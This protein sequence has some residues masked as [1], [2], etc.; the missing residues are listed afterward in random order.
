MHYNA[1]ISYKHAEHDI[2]IAETVQHSL[3][4]FH[5]PRKLQKK[6]GMK[7]IQRVFR[8]KDE[9]PITSDLS[10]EIAT[11]L[12][13]ADRL[14]VICSPAAKESIWVQREIEFFLR[15]HSKREIFTVL[16]EGEPVEVI[17]EILLTGERVIKD[18]YGREKIVDV[19]VEPLS[20]DFR[21]SLKRAKKEELPRLAS[22]IIGCSYDELMNRRRQYKMR[23]MSIIFAGVMLLAL[24]FGAYMYLSKKEIHKN[25]L[26]S[27][28]NQSRYLANESQRVLDKEQRILALQLALEALPDK[29]S[30]RPVTAEAVR[31][32]TDASLAYV[33]LQ[34]SNIDSV[35]NYRLPNMI[36]DFLLSPEGTTLAARDNGNTL[37]IW[38]TRTHE[39]IIEVSD[40]STNIIGMIYADDSTFLVWS[41][42]KI[43]AYNLTKRES[44]WTYTAS[45]EQFVQK[46]S[47]LTD[48]NCVLLAMTNQS[49]GRFN[50][51]TGGLVEKYSIPK[52]DNNNTINP[53]EYKLSPDGK[54]L[55]YYAYCNDM[56]YIVCIY[57][58]A[59]G[60]TSY[61]T[62]ITGRRIRDLCWGD[63]DH[64]VIATVTDD[65]NSSALQSGTYYLNE[66]HTYIICLDA[67]TLAKKWEHDLVSTEVVLK[68]I[69]LPIPQDKQV[70]YACGN[71]AEIYDIETGYC[72]YS[73]N[74]NSTIIDMSD[75]DGDGWPLYITNDGKLAVPSPN[76]G[77]HAVSAQQEFTDNI[78]KVMI[79]NG[80][81]VHQ[82]TSSEI[83]FYGLYVYDEEW[84][85]VDEKAGI[86]VET[87]YRDYYINDEVLA[88]F[89]NGSTKKELF[90]IDPNTNKLMQQIE[91]Q[92]DQLS[93]LFKILGCYDGYLYIVQTQSLDMILTKINIH[94]GEFENTTIS[95]KT[96]L[97]E[98]LCSFYDNKI[99]Y[100]RDDGDKKY[101]IVIYDLATGKSK[102]YPIDIPAALTPT[103]PI[104][105]PECGSIYYTSSDKDIFVDEKTGK[106]T[107]A[108]RPYGYT[109]STYADYS[110]DAGLYIITDTTQIAAVDKNGTLKYSFTC[111]GTTPLGIYCFEDMFL[112]P[113]TNGN[114]YRYKASTGEFIGKSDLTTYST[115]SYPVTFQYD[116]KSKNLY[117]QHIDMLDIID[118]E[119]W[120]EIANINNC[121]GRH[122]PTDHFFTYTSGETGGHRVGYFKHYTVV[123]LIEKG[124]KLLGGLEMTDE[125]KSQYGIDD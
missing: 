44:K 49:V 71:I 17:P 117:I 73:H 103:A 123:E 119:S 47:I 16:A 90:L 95:G 93:A 43:T 2:K 94:T 91:L 24:A 83:I 108:E 67:K 97:A 115:M 54:R 36:K 56:D 33:S 80:V 28:R 61:S 10:D 86:R 107:D 85:E 60:Q 12:E 78:D 15:N 38:D 98:N 41:R 27:L 64:I 8:D 120:Y 25:F 84:Q 51:E 102:D 76:R 58:I 69:F 105:L 79:K 112:V 48:D 59:T 89:S 113:Y 100:I 125:E 19:N 88:I 1:F 30:E 72:Y 124:N 63:D 70:A 46:E 66:D 74:V 114:L 22:G 6:Y 29:G 39:K 109:Y 5:I 116:K 111:P 68:S 14:I 121:M 50:Y 96:Y 110:V 92:S 18:E 65:F 32:L 3:E 55:A 122:A 26:N 9:L 87:I 13:N 37:I 104:Y 7:R 106:V 45:P 81:Y 11:A 35:W 34:G 23:R 40:P 57:D 21:G 82:S 52:E 62:V 99:F 31:A 101:S 20:C 42:E 118:T 77:E 53:I 4:H 75:R